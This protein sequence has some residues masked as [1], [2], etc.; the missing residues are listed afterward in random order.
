MKNKYPA[1][2]SWIIT[3]LTDLTSRKFLLT[4]WIMKT[5]L[6]LFRAGTLKNEML[7]A[8][9]F[10]GPAILYIYVNGKIKASELKLK[11]GPGGVEL[12]GPGTGGQNGNGNQ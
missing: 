11:I 1:H 10:L 3:K 12:N 2:R 8:G 5:V 7:F 9:M 4:I 6:D